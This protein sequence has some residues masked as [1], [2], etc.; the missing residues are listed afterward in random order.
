MKKLLLTALVIATSLSAPFAQD[1]PEK[2]KEIWKLKTDYDSDRRGLNEDLN[3]LWSSSNKAIT[4]F[5]AT[6]GK[7]IWGG[8]FEKLLKNIGNVDEQVVMYDAKCVMVF[9][10]SRKGDQMAVMDLMTGKVLWTSAKYEGVT[11]DNIVFISEMEAFAISTK[12]SLFLVKARTGEEMWETKKFKGV[13]GAY[14][15][16]AADKSMVMINFKPNLLASLFAGFKNQLVKIN[17]TN[18]DVIWDTEYYGLVERKVVTREFVLD[19]AVKED[20]VFLTMNGLQVF[21]FKTGKPIWSARYDL[22]IGNN[23]NYGVY[24]AIADPLYVGSDVYLFDML[25][26]YSQYIRKYDITTGKMIWS[27]PEIKNAYIAPNMYKFDDVIVLQVGGVAQ[28][29]EWRSS[30]NSYVA[31]R[32]PVIRLK[33]FRPFNVQGFNAQT[34]VQLWESERFKRGITNSFPFEDKLMICSGK[35]LYSL[36]TKTGKELY[37]VLLKED[38]IEDATKI[39]DYKDNVI[40]IAERGVSAHSKSNGNK[41]WTVKTKDDGEFAGVFGSVAFYETDRGDQFAINLETGKG[42]YYESDKKNEITKNGEFIYVFNGDEIFKV[43]AK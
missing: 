23:N 5:D 32:Y 10:R 33:N 41:I 3:I 43:A 31:I 19:L 40:I 38:K 26:R 7:I 25:N 4:V 20:R 35:A 15:Y 6:S 11:Q 8:E 30:G 37:E 22:N 21:D 29:Q 16:S 24:D 34:G 27:T 14:V 42:K 12:T 13:V 36:D 18:G 39:V 1:K 17:M 2:M 28:V 9:E